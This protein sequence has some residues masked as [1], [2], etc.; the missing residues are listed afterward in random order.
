MKYITKLKLIRIERC[1]FYFNYFTLI[2]SYFTA[3]LK[4]SELEI[5]CLLG[6][7]KSK[8]RFMVRKLLY[9]V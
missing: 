3:M 1:F 4:V 5:I 7:M 6:E 2:K 9:F 8:I